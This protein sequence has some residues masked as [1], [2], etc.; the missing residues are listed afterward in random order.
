MN[1]SQILSSI[2]YGLAGVTRFSGRDGNRLFWPWA[3]FV[4]LLSHAAAMAV[5]FP[6]MFDG[7][8]RT[9][10]TMSREDFAR[11]PAAADRLAAQMMTGL[12]W[13]WMPMAVIEAAVILLLAAAVTRR[14]HD[15]DRTALWGLL[16]LPFMAIGLALMPEAF[17]LVAAPSRPNPGLMLL[18]AST[19]F[20]WGALLWLGFL[21]AGKGS[22]GAN[23]FGPATRQTP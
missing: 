18:Y 9:V 15:R 2:R 4:F 12:G 10:E 5:M 13:L 11:D 23:R 20:S 17:E 1:F 21:L 22:E 8:M 14:L 7:I 6:A 3:G 19:P 16:P